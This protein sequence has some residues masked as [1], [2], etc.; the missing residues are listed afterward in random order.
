MTD[1]FYSIGKQGVAWQQS[2]KMQWLKN[3][4]IK[5]SYFDEVISKIDALSAKFTV[6]Q[7]GEL[8]YA[9]LVSSSKGESSY[10]LFL[11]KSKQWQEALPTILVTGGVHGYETSGIHGALAF[12]ADKA[13]N[14]HGKFNIIAFPCISPWGYETINRWNPET[15]D[16]NRSFYDNSPSQEAA[17]VL[18]YLKE[19]SIEAFCHIDL[20]E[21][22]D[23]DNSEFIPARAARDAKPLEIW[24]IP[25]GFYL[26]AD[27][28]K[29]QN[30][31]QKAII[32]SVE[33]VTHIALADKDSN[34][35]GEPMTHFGVI[36]YP[37]K[38]LG[39]CMG[40]SAAKYVTTTEVYPDSPQATPALCIEAQVAVITGALDFLLK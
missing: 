11:V 21:T 12:L 33:K 19:V 7:Y 8:D 2:E 20:H 32:S 31:F 27:S 28:E 1:Y 6:E 23:T 16:P 5:R 26:V 3:Q 29:E 14:Y 9:G 35:I 25:D 18:R 30:D 37:A 34:L 38:A 15:I 36:N 39:L 17:A 13:T 10:P 24:E 40:M 22:T 4:Q